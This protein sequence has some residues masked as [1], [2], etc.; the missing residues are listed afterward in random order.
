MDMT[1][2]QIGAGRRLAHLGERLGWSW[3]VYNPGICKN[4]ERI[5][6]RNA[7]PLADA[8]L[9]EQPEARS[10]IDI[11]C[12]AGIIAAEFQ[13]RGLRVHGCEYSRTARRR[14]IHRGVNVFP[15]D[16][17]RSTGVPDHL[18]SEMIDFA[19]TTEVAEHIPVVFADGFV[20]FIASLQTE[21]VFFTAAQPGQGGEGHINEQPK[22]Y[23]IDKFAARGFHTDDASAERIRD[24]LRANNASAFLY[25]NIIVFC[26]P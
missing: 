5:A 15:F 26:R 7:K 6:F 10:M 12:G 11:G 13:S 17:S 8:L 25:N 24:S 22:A 14:A 4:Y 18:R 9:A 21:T 16:L 3:M 2:I 1:R 23:W 20:D 19:L